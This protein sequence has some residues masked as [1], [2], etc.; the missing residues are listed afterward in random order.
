[1]DTPPKKLK[2][3]R[4]RGSMHW[5]IRGHLAVGVLLVASVIGGVGGWAAKTEISGAVIASG[6]V[7]VDSNVKTVQHRVGGTVSDIL[8]RNGDRVTAGQPMVRLDATIAKA[9]LAIVNKRL[10]E[11]NVRGARLWAE[12]DGADQMTLPKLD[13]VEAAQ[14]QHVF[15]AERRL[16]DLRRTARVGQKQQLS[17]RVSQL[18]AE[19]EGLTVQ[20]NSKVRE[21]ALMRRELES[22]RGLWAKKLTSIGKITALEREATRLEGQ[23]GQLKTT[24]AARRGRISEIE[25]KIIQI[26]RDLAGEVARELRGID[27]SKGEFA[28]RKIAAEDRLQSMTIRASQAGIVHQS[29]VHTVGGV[30]SPGDTLMLVVPT[31]DK[32]TVEA[33]VA[34]RDID[35]LRAGQATLLRFSAFNLRST[36]ELN[37][38]V[39]NISAD[40]TTDQRTGARYYTVRIEVPADEVKR[41]GTAKLVPG[42]PVEAFIKT[43]DRTVLSYLVKPMSDQVT[44][45]FRE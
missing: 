3:K 31:S 19:I 32:L 8:V 37:G 5:S 28:E 43:G 6:L 24:I 25:L 11:L 33:R 44:R 20:V 9:S 7:V 34:P 18:E 27:A 35:Q 38:T 17:Q 42:M 23:R 2:A 39:Q 21:I 13:G 12:R 1:M 40:V 29:K 4:G 41:L 30:I 14:L 10:T 22:A 16:F 15:A 36:P 26:D 45:A